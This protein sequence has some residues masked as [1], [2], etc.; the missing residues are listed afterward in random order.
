MT[1]DRLYYTDSYLT[2]FQGT[3]LESAEGGRRVYLDRTAFYPTSGGQPFDTGTLGGIRVVD[4]LDEEDR[5]AHLLEAPLAV[6]PVTG[7]VDWT[8]R[9]D[10][11]QQHTG[12]HLLSAVIAELFG[13]ETV[14]VHF[15]PEIAT[16]DL[17]AVALSVDEVRRAELRAN[18]VVTENRPVTVAF[19]DASTAT[20]LRKASAR[21]GEI[22]I[23]TIA[24][25]DRSACGGTH[26]RTTGEVGPILLRR[27]ERVKKLVRLEFLCGTRAVQRARADFD[28]LSAMAA[29]GST[30]LDEVPALFEKLRNDL[31]AGETA[32]RALDEELN[33]YRAE[34]LY[35]AAVP[36]AAGRRVIVHRPNTATVEALRGLANAVTTRPG[37]VFVGTIVTPPT[38][39]LATSADSGLDAG[40]ILKPILAALGGRGGGQA[41][42]AQG[43]VP[44]PQEIET[45][46]ANI[47]SAVG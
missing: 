18:A 34:A 26:V 40:A 10:H 12:Q 31:K 39:L 20:G 4:V 7:E 2:G 5:I 24:G 27:V 30:G 23:V 43:T 25:L 14:S 22:R 45:A 29:A 3:V 17:D 8:R 36:N 15:G 1:T 44:G 33:R 6:G 16:L 9:F 41:R 47:A 42:Q 37:T 38:L 46:L 32:R 13:F 11:M 19:E 21:T 28:A 35:A